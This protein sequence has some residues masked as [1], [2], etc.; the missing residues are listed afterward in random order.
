LAQLGT[1][2]GPQA[3]APLDLISTISTT[4]AARKAAP[5]PAESS[6]VRKNLGKFMENMEKCGNI[7]ENHVKI[8][9]KMGKYGKHM[10]KIWEINVKI[11]KKLGKSMEHSWKTMETS[12]KINGNIW[13][14][15]EESAKKQGK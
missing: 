14:H 4:E 1:A 8:W 6:L 2:R 10:E 15:M 9:K 13:K 7:W 12:G 11:R 5:G 3:L